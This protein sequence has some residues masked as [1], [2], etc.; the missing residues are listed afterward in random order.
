MGIVN[1]SLRV[2]LR[3]DQV[4][5]QVVASVNNKRDLATCYKVVEGGIAQRISNV[6]EGR[7]LVF[8][9]QKVHGQVTGK[10]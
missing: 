9:K 7:V 8:K 3:K 4:G 10:G 6:S 2:F 5:K 1:A